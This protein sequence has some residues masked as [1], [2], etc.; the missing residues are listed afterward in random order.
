MLNDMKH[1]QFV[2]RQFMSYYEKNH[3]GAEEKAMVVLD[4]EL[5]M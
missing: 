4:I 3:L 2:A 1:E 5:L